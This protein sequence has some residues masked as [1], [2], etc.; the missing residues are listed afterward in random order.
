MTNLERIYENI[1]NFHL[2]S[3]VSSALNECLN[4][5]DYVGV[6]DKQFLNDLTENIISGERKELKSSRTQH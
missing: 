4:K 5:K 6:E 2:M 3:F 1:L